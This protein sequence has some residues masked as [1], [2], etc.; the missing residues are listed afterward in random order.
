MKILAIDPGVTTGYCMAEIAPTI[1]KSIEIRIQ[2]E[3]HLDDVE[4]C[5]DRIEAF[6]PRYIVCEDFEYRNKSRSGLVLFSVQLIGIASLYE[7]KSREPYQCSLYMQKA[8][9]GKGYYTNPLLKQLGVYKAGTVWE[10]SMDATRHLL[11]WLTFNAGYQYT[12]G[13]DIKDLVKL[14]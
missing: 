7:L 9:E 13:H 4:D 10:H 3:Q 1:L 8:A 5:W 2:P 11:H 14:V 12:Q 6:Q